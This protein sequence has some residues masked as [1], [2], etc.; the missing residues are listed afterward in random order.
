MLSS[1]GSVEQ[2]LEK[3]RAS[4]QDFGR[5]TVRLS[6]FVRSMTGSSFETQGVQ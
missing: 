3:P 5:S 4:V 1:T 2:F 6:S